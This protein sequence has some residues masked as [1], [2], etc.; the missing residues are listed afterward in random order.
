MQTVA[1][2]QNNMEQNEADVNRAERQ[3]AFGAATPMQNDF[4]VYA[5]HLWRARGFIVKAMLA[6][7][8]AAAVLSLELPRMYQSSVRLMPPANRRSQASSLLAGAAS[9][10]LGEA[11]ASALGIQTPSA[12]YEQV[13]ESRTVA[14]HLIDKFDLRHVYH[15]STYA[16]AR[17]RLAASTDIAN[18]RKS[19]VIALIV[20]AES[21][22][23]AAGL[24]AGYVDELNALMVQT[25]TSAAHREREFLE[26]RL[27][28]IEQDLGN[29]TTE[30][31]Q[32]TSNN[33]VVVGEEQS[34]AIFTAAEALRSQ[35][36]MAKADLQALQQAYTPDNERVRAAQARLNELQRQLAQMQGTAGSLN[37]SA[38]GFPTIRELPLLGA[39]YTGIYRQLM[40]EQ[41][42]YEALT[43]QYE[44]AKVEEARDLPTVRLIDDADVPE[45][46]LPS[47]RILRVLAG[48]FLAFLF[49]CA[50]VLGQDWWRDSRSPWRQ[51]GGEIAEGMAADVSRIRRFRGFR[52]AARRPDSQLP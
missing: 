26:T 7:A 39:K 8:I 19:G 12:L 45:K 17:L 50:Y 20:T 21:P 47:K 49:S 27:K 42:V 40:V 35:A 43:R 13:L 15:T 5:S 2:M 28:G 30:L 11:G 51:F 22:K 38:N 32:F 18:D 46:K 41:A 36:I 6:G 3:P 25:D 1:T 4:V 37:Q 31:S 16:D 23:L 14:D 10:P 24:A 44:T 48:A 34:R 33:T 52:K 9:G 29:Y